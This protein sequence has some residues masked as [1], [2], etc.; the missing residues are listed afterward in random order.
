MG[1]SVLTPEQGCWNQVWA[2]A[3]A[4]KTDLVNGGFYMPVGHLADDKLDKV[5]RDGELAGRLWQ[6][7]EDVLDRVE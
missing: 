4:K 1:S 6:W 3:A 7:T 2:A 5:A